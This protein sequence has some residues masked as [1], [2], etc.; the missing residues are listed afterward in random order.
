MTGH[1]LDSLPGCPGVGQDHRLRRGCGHV[2]RHQLQPAVRHVGPAVQPARGAGH[3]AKWVT[4]RRRSRGRGRAHWEWELQQRWAP[5][6][7]GPG[8]RRGVGC[9]IRDRTDKQERSGWAGRGGGAG[10]D[11]LNDN[12]NVVKCEDVAIM[13]VLFLGSDTGILNGRSCPCRLPPRA[14][15]RGG[16]AAVA[17]RLAV[18]PPRPVRQLHGGRAVDADVCA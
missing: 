8:G 9:A 1:P 7:Q 4:A 3:A 17:L 13:D 6:Q 12:D 18:R 11:R 14:R 10:G 2:H 16:C 15:P 5:L